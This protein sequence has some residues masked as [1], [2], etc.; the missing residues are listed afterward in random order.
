MLKPKPFSP[1][2]HLAVPSSQKIRC[3]LN[4]ESLLDVV[5][6]TLH[7]MW[8]YFRFGDFCLFVCLFFAGTHYLCHIPAYFLESTVKF[9]PHYNKGVFFPKE[10]YPLSNFWISALS[11]T[12]TFYLL[13]NCNHLLMCIIK[14][15]LG[16]IVLY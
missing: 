9:L 14:L 11:N 1:M 6:I 10:R 5:G 16:N 7:M 4:A 2:V 15:L 3:E 13:L 12:P 8:F